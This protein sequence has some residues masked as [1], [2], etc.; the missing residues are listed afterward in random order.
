M[1]PQEI[2]NITKKL[3]NRELISKE[4]CVKLRKAEYRDIYELL[5]YL[6]EEGMNTSELD[7]KWFVNN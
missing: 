3:L 1:T 6:E 4:L 7:L 2:L 5:A